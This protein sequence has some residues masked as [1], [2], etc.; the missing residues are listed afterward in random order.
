[1][2]WLDHL[3]R[4]IGHL[5][6]PQLI[7]YVTLLNALVFILLQVNPSF[8]SAIC[9]DPSKV[10]EGEVWRLVSHLFLPGI[11]GGMPPWIQMLM[12]VMF[13]N[14][15]GQGLEEAMGPFRVN[16]YYALGAFGTTLAAFIT[17]RSDGGFFLNNSLLF[18]FATFFADLEILLFFVIPFKIKWLAWFDAVFMVYLFFARDAM[19]KLAVVV[20][21][22][23]Y[24]IFFGPGLLSR[25][26]HRMPP[27][28][29]TAAEDADAEVS[30]ALHRCEVCSRTELTDPNLEFRVAADGA[31]YCR[32]HLPR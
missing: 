25:F 26:Q 6:I 16:L 18:A 32:Q 4:R 30:N 22:L 31:E 19:G 10:L 8:A 23:N 29:F 9:L 17:G 14:W 28:R 13:L 27:T 15:I 5:A 24:A 12:Y 1:M 21:V 20:S 3:E 7:R 2:T 11:E